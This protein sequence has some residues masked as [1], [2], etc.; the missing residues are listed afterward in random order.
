MS[1]RI[2]ARAGITGLIGATVLYAG[3]RGV[4]HN[5]LDRE[6]LTA[7]K[8]ADARGVRSALA[9]GADPNARGGTP[10]PW[11]DVSAKPADITA[12]LHPTALALL[13]A[14]SNVYRADGSVLPENMTCLKELLDRGADPN[15]ITSDDATQPVLI[16]AARAGYGA[17]VR[18]MLDHGANP[19]VVD[20]R[21]A[22][23]LS[24]AVY[25]ND[26][27]TAVSLIQHGVDV[28]ARFRGGTALD[29]AIHYHHPKM[30]ALLRYY[31]KGD[32]G[33]SAAGG[34]IGK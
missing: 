33:K 4:R 9:R 22:N 20:S 31:A 15:V 28:N 29:W 18:A 27:Q 19:N 16:R 24:D 8:R 10:D 30:V 34:V 1:R 7:V 21:G 25:S 2:A 6:L 17:S 3:L 14:R 26:V 5:E 32:G 11:W 23:A 12:V 13:F